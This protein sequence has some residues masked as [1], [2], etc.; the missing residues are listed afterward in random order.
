MSKLQWNVYNGSIS[1][2][3]IKVFN[4]F[5]HSSFSDKV[6]KLRRKKVSRDEFSKELKSLAMYYFWSKCEYEVVIT[7]WPPYIDQKELERIASEG[8]YHRY[9]VELTMGEKVDVYQQLAL[10]WERFVDYVYLA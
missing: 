5:D 9:S 10:N 1:R 3:E 4:V 6:D 7:S 8:H 2:H